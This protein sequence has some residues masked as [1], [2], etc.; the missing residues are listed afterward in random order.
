MTHTKATSNKSRFSQ[1]LKTQEAEAW[2][3]KGNDEYEAD[4]YV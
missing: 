4:N 2:L 3:G 1:F